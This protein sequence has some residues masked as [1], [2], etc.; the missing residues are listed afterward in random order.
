M[1]TLNTFESANHARMIKLA[2][3]EHPYGDPFS[4]A[5]YGQFEKSKG[6][7]MILGVVASVVTMGASLPMLASASLATQLAGGAMMAGGVLNGV[8][9]VTGNKKLMKIGGVLS[10]AG[11][12]GAGLSS[13][14][15]GLGMGA[16]ST[17]VQNMA[18]SMMESINGLGVNV[19][20]PELVAS[21]TSA[22]QAASGTVGLAGDTAG[23]AANVVGGNSAP[24]GGELATEAATAAA[25]TG[26]TN[27][28]TL[29]GLEAASGGAKPGI[30][31][32][33]QAPAANVVGGGS[34]PLGNSVVTSPPSSEGG[35]FDKFLAATKANPEL[36]KIG[37][38]MVKGFAESAMGTDQEAQMNALIDKYK[39]DTRLINTQADYAAYTAANAKAQV[40]MIS[41]DDPQLDAKVQDAKAKGI[42]VAFIP[43][44]GANFNASQPKAWGAGT[45]SA[46]TTNAQTPAR[47]GTF[48][49][50]GA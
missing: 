25:G 32:A 10:L 22:G 42:P 19:F 34:A 1:Q 20:N 23:L 29:A 18:G 16:G 38:E 7:G 31:Q 12:V 11:G 45:T 30:I 26:T 40:A 46:G 3:N 49:A 4:G 47:Q 17:G 21:A 35:I 43:S 28:T 48:A 9:A 27:T 8:G 41:A 36:T 13:M 6:L 5:P 33:A 50:Q 39:A 14:T 37:G 24:L 44:I 2:M 15:G